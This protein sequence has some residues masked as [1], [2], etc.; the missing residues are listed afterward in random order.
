[1]AAK[2]PLS[3]RVAHDPKL[4][5]RVLAN[6][7]LRSKLPDK[8]LTA[9]QRSKRNVNTR[10][11]APLVPGS[12]M[13]MRDAA[14]T[15]NAQTQVKYGQAEQAL[16]TELGHAQGYAR[17]VPGWYQQYQNDL[18]THAQNVQNIGAGA[19]TA[20][21]NQASGI[22]SLDQATLNAQ[23][24]AA[25]S[26]AAQRGATAGNLGPTASDASTVRQAML[27]ALAGGQTGA[28]TANS[29]YAD[30]IAKVV[31]PGQ[32]LQAQTQAAGKVSDVR[33]KQTQ[34][35]G[36][37]GA[38]NLSAR[39]QIA[40]DEL[41]N[42]LAQQA[43]TGTQAT[44][45]ANIAATTA[46]TTKTQADIDYFNKHGYY[47]RTGPAP[48]PSA[49]S[50]YGPGRPG[51]N[52]LHY[53]Y[54]EWNALTPKQQADARAGKGAP[55]KPVDQATQ[56]AKDFYA[57]YGVKPAAT[58]AVGNAK[59]EIQ[60]AQNLVNQIRKSDPTLTRQQIGQLL[61][62]GQP[63]STK[64][65]QESMAIPKVKGLWATV[66]LDLWK[67]NG[68]ISAGTASKLHSAGYSVKTLGLTTPDAS[69]SVYVKPPK[70]ATT[71]SR[72]DS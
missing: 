43:L 16:G 9:A 40:A 10:L 12:P 42:V 21:A 54:D 62:N 32:K 28:N 7:G 33:A 72:G 70:P 68:K 65:G 26:E 1:M 58:A 2:Q 3:V 24:G 60:T 22:R 69:S 51:M 4:L 49:P 57:K 56:Y 19:N 6:P 55:K 8:Y 39:Q 18:A 64:K 50:G 59:N 36:E 30:T 17:D 5:A 34:L 45:K 52:S 63:G 46:R 53:T 71:G 38:F 61:L 48:K 35:A 31:A 15:A 25:N 67:F 27:A 11:N 23:Q 29:T 44:Q 14:R 41:K 20:L 13:T 47:P 66:A 37:K